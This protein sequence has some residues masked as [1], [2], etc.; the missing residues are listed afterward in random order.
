MFGR[1]DFMTMVCV[2]I[3]CW[4]AIFQVQIEASQQANDEPLELE[5]G[6]A[7]ARTQGTKSDERV[8][9]LFSILVESCI[10]EA[11]KLESLKHKGNGILKMRSEKI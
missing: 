10:D 3:F 2:V 5:E 7:F 11:V 9:Q 1:K 8:L 6:V 4:L